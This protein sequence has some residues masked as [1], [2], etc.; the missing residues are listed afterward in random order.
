MRYW[1]YSL[2][3]Q[4]IQCQ[5]KGV[6]HRVKSRTLRAVL[7]LFVGISP[8]FLAHCTS[9]YKKSVGGD[10]DQV[11]TRIFA[12]DLNGVWQGCLDS[13]KDY[14]LEISSRESGQIQTKWTENTSQKNFIDSFGA[15]NFYLKAQV[16]YRLSVAKGIYDGRN[17][18]KVTVQKEQLVQ[19]DVLEGW[20][21]VSTDGVDEHT[22]LYRIGRLI[23]IQAKL[24]EIEE[25]KVREQLGPPETTPLENETE[26]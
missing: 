1:F 2:R 7:S 16:R 17:A 14:P 12:A 23:I 5:N 25:R 20:Q 4:G 26:I 18:V 9:A 22:L 3:K 19:Y 11:F 15:G 6:I 8:L 10:T 24:A 13:L 21:P